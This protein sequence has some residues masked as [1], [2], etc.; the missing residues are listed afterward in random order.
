MENGD[1]LINGPGAIMAIGALLA[2]IPSAI[3]YFSTYDMLIKH[4]FIPTIGYIGLAMGVII[5]CCGFM[6]WD[7]RE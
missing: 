3:C 1:S 2:L 5:F 4:P 6:L 7:T